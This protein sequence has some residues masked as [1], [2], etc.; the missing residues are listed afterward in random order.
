[1]WKHQRR[2]AT[3][4]HR[5]PAEARGERGRPDG[6]RRHLPLGQHGHHGHQNAG[7]DGDPEHRLAAPLHPWSFGA[8]L[9]GLAEL[10]RHPDDDGDDEKD[11]EDAVRSL[12]R[13]NRRDHGWSL[14]SG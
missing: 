13:T 5:T 1:V 7:D 11:R 6:C 14:R 10:G 2:S 9:E 12:P 4:H 3:P 8:A